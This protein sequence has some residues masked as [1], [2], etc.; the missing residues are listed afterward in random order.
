MPTE[1]RDSGPNVTKA[2]FGSYLH[3]GFQSV[4]WELGWPNSPRQATLLAGL[5]GGDGVS[6][7]A[8]ALHVEPVPRHRAQREIG[9]ARVQGE[10]KREVSR[11]AGRIERAAAKRARAVAEG[12]DAAL[13]SGAGIVRF[14][15]FVTVTVPEHAEMDAAVAAIRNDAGVGGIRLA[16]CAG[17]MDSAFAVGVVPIGCLPVGKRKV[18]V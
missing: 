16:R 15:G 14:S 9:A 6:R 17:W 12:Q 10:I 8:I 18:L 1:A 3:D 2:R 4:T 13:A 5:T 7:R 11:K